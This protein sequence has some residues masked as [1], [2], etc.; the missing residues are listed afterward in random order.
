MK[1]FN[2]CI[3]VLSRLVIVLLCIIADIIFTDHNAQDITLFNYQST[4]ILTN[5]L[6]KPFTKWD[7]AYYLNI[8]RDGYTKE[9]ELAFFPLFPL[10]IRI[11]SKCIKLILEFI[12]INIYFDDILIISGLI[13][14][15]TSFILSS[16]ILWY[17][18]QSIYKNNDNIQNN[19]IIYVSYLTYIFN[20]AN[21]FFASIYT[22]S[23]YSLFAWLSFLLIENDSYWYLSYVTFFIASSIR[24]NGILNIIIAAFI[25]IRQYLQIEKSVIKNNNYTM[26]IILLVVQYIIFLSFFVLFI[27]LPSFIFDTVSRIY[28]CGTSKD[29]FSSNNLITRNIY[30]IYIN[31]FFK[32][33]T[34]ENNVVLQQSICK[35]SFNGNTIYRYIQNKYW[36]VGFFSYYQ[37][38]QI[39]N[40]VLAMPIIII[41]YII[42]KYYII[43]Y[44]NH[45][46]FLK[47]KKKYVSMY[48]YCY[49]I[50]SYLSANVYTLH[51][52][53]V[54]SI[55]IC[56]A[57]IQIITRLLLSSCPIIYLGISIFLNN[58]I[59]ISRNCILLY[60]FIFNFLGI[61]FHVN[62]YPWT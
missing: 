47:Q 51:L 6:L 43:N 22:E 29:F 30:Y 18:I 19:N 46:V 60:F 34:I 9:Q 1:Q 10:T 13:I 57:H 42:I 56:F 38:K 5:K 11:L 12:N 59:Y 17:L 53:L 54:L 28:I 40:F 52:L 26:K 8:A 61:L 4:S 33:N 62:Y 37:L 24:S 58:N 39:P 48:S 35:Y 21:I 2:V 20:P 23:F 32:N 41:S 25:L 15:N 3:V 31:I 44:N 55:G 7:S 49:F 36:N 45:I 14:S 16:W 27:G 50:I